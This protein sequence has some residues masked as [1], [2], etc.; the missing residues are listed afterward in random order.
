M[1]FITL[2][3]IFTFSLLSKEPIYYGIYGNLNLN[4]FNADFQSL[5]GF[6][7]CCPGFLDGSGRGFSFGLNSR[8]PISKTDYFGVKIGL[9]DFSGELSRSEQTFINLPNIGKTTGEFTHYIDASISAIS[10][11]PYYSYS[12]LDK[13]NLNLGLQLS[14]L[15]SGSH[16]SVEKIT[17]PKNTGTFWDEEKNESTNSRSRNQQ[18]GDIPNLSAFDM[19]LTLGVNYQIQMNKDN[20]LRLLPEV[21][22][23]YGFTNIV[24]DNDWKMNSLNF[25]VNLF[26]VPTRYDI[27]YEEINNIDTVEQVKDYISDEYIIVGKS[28]IKETEKIE[29]DKKYITKYISRTDTLFTKGKE[30]IIDY[31][32]DTE[33]TKVYDEV[34]VKVELIA[35]DKDNSLNEL[36]EIK[37]K[38]ELTSEVYPLLPIIFFD[39]NSL[40]LPSRYSK[41]NNKN[42]F[43]LSQIEP[44]PINYN[45]NTLNI[46]GTRMIEN[47]SSNISIKGYIDPT[48]ESECSLAIQRANSIKDYLVNVYKISENRILVDNN[49]DD[50]IPKDLTR[51]QSEEGYQENRRVEISSN[52]PQ[53]LFAVTNTKYEEPIEIEPE[54]ILIKVNADLVQAKK[55]LNQNEVYYPKNKNYKYKMLDNWN[56][57]I[58]QGSTILLNKNGQNQYSEIPFE[59]SRK[60][61]TELRDEIDISVE[62]EGVSSSGKTN[63]DFK[64][65]K[66]VKDTST[67]EVEKLTLTVFKVSQSSLDNRIKEEIR[68]FIK[69]LDENSV[70]EITGYSDDL[71]NAEANKNLSAVRAEE[72]RKYISSIFPKANFTKVIGTGSEKYPP[73]IKSYKTPEERFISRTVEISIRKRIE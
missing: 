21:S 44:N 68:K 4:S 73:G 48:T 51:T 23:R 67:T 49:I 65:Y 7:T 27:Q 66:V 57:T 29:K 37:L 13:F 35:L 8:F 15:V 38:V 58:Y 47:P 12:F 30:P 60:N 41:V 33:P 55:V 24:S 61:A 1:K 3:L 10:L 18:S 59:F 6:N 26:Y 43:D 31:A 9:S 52:M 42:E 46:I 50:C 28:S 40:S 53:L 5:D 64:K 56:L 16:N 22:Y 20:T 11:E 36:E 25:G 32:K 72:V 34:A 19:G 45:R 17:K 2:I 39:E 62:L 63:S 14:S 71:G 70:I 54:N 69:N